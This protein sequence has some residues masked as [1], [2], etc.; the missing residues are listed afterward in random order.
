MRTTVDENRKFADFIANKLNS[1]SSKICVCLP[2]KGISA[3]GAPGKPFYDPEATGTLLHELQR[4][5]QTD[6]IR[7]VKV[8]PHHINDLEFASALVDAF[9]E[10]NEKKGSTHPQVAIPESVEHF[11]EDLGS[12]S[13]KS[14][15]G[16]IVYAPNEFP[17]TKPVHN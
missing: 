11:H 6:D 8:Y 13:N 2:E 7:Q 1:S 12:V 14:S 10:V 16:A 9:L 5:I 17:D 3:L 4:L 15:F